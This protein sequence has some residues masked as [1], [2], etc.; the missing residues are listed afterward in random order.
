[1]FRKVIWAAAINQN[2]EFFPFSPVWVSSKRNWFTRFICPK[3][4]SRSVL[5]LHGKVYIHV[6]IKVYKT[7]CKRY[8]WRWFREDDHGAKDFFLTVPLEKLYL[9]STFGLSHVY[10]KGCLKRFIAKKPCRKKI[11]KIAY[12]KKNKT[13]AIT[14]CNHWAKGSEKS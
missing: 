4:N 10:C 14:F 11:W 2:Q 1:M 8:L 5:K 3:T 12:Q 7:W 6:A 13:S 9:R